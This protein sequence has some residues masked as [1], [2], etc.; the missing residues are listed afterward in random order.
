MATKLALHLAFTTD[1]SKKVRVSV[2]SP[3][4][5]IDSAAVDAAMQTIVNKNVFVF[6]QGRIVSS[7]PAEQ[8]Q[9]DTTSIS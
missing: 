9:T 4:Q 5:P 7:L 3:K 6:P 1:Q 8:T 2:P